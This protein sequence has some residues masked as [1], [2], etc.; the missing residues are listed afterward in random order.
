MVD[1][2]KT[3]RLLYIIEAALEYFISIAVGTVYLAR[4]TTHIGMSDALTGILSSFVSLGCGFQ[5]I[6]IFL[7]NKRPVKRWVTAGH[8]L[9]QALFALIYLVPIFPL[10]TLQKTII[11]VALLLIAQIVHNVINAPKINWFMSLVD[12]KKRGRFTASKEIV[13]LTSGIAF[14]YALG[15]VVD[16]FNNRGEIETAFIICGIGLFAL[17]MLHS[18]TLIFSKEKVEEQPK[19]SVKENVKGLLKNKTLF[20]LIMVSVLWNIANYATTSFTGTYQAK[21][22][23][24]TTTFSSVIIMVGSF[25]R[26]VLSR[27]MGK[28]ADKTSFRRMLSFCFVLEAFAFGIN[29]FTT[30]AN[31]EWLY[32]AYYILHCAGMAGINSSVINL[33]YDYVE[34]DQRTSALALQQTFAGFAGF[35]ITLLLSPLVSLIQGAQQ[36]GSSPLYAQQ[37]MSIISFVIVLA[38]IV[39]INTVIKRLKKVKNTPTEEG[40]AQEVAPET[41]IVQEVAAD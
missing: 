5:L 34:R 2:Y 41:E 8:I 9:S 26:A 20:K 28:Y 17:M 19:A 23:A 31:G 24:F 40:E 22:L 16:Y 39:Y 35:F 33:I 27:P 10:N 13:S 15:A 4:I 14:S 21:E 12:D 36:S 38:E 6:A 37:I 3:S 25:I 18:L 11:F 32:F 30:P 1:K 29:I 7:A